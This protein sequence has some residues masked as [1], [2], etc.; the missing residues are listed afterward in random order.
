MTNRPSHSGLNRRD[1]LHALGLAAVGWPL[2]S[3]SAARAAAVSSAPATPQSG[4]KLGVAAY[5]LHALSLERAVAA[6]RT[7]HIGYVSVFRTHAPMDGPPEPVLA[8]VAAFRAAGIE[9]MST[10]VTDLPND[11]AVV[12]RVFENGRAAGLRVITCKPAADAF[13]LIER[14]VRT[15]D[16]KLAIH[17]HG[18]EDDLYPTPWQAWKA[19][20]PYDPRIG[21]C[22]D[23][24]H[25]AR[26]GAD[27][28][29]AIRT[30]ASRLYDFHLKDSVAL[31]GAKTDTP[32]ELGRGKIDVPGILAALLAAGYSGQVGVEYEVA[33]PDPTP[34]LGECD[35]YARGVLTALAKPEIPA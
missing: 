10:G 12:R 32:V 28:L 8:A 19:V 2:L 22:I 25:S 24:G 23:V 13:P 14:Y 15:Y 26:A 1:A 16:I 6:L 35:G 7:L 17:N 27:P 11:E 4:L 5:S 29:P 30:C 33:T 3:A 34:G 9:V 18:P 20:Q 21:L 31:V